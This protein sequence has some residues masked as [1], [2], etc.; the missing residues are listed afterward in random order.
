MKRKLDKAS[1]HSGRA[2]SKGVAYNPNHNTLEAS[3]IHQPH[4]DQE[5]IHLNQYL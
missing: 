4:I 1:V 5:R 3:R 2:N